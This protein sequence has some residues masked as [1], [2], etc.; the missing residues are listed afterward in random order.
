MPILLRLQHC[1]PRPRSPARRRSAAG[2]A[3]ALGSSPS[4]RGSC[5]CWCWRPLSLPQIPVQGIRCQLCHLLLPEPAGLHRAAD[6]KRALMADSPLPQSLMVQHTCV[7]LEISSLWSTSQREDQD[8]ERLVRPAAGAQLPHSH[9]SLA[10]ELC[11]RRPLLACHAQH[12]CTDLNLSAQAWT[13]L[14]GL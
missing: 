14:V 11:A 5:C 8:L 1:A 10:P 6:L 9:Q 4:V 2:V 12:A 3:A 7:L 13:C